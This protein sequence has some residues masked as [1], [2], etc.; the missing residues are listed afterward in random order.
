MVTSKFLTLTSLSK[1]SL[2]TIRAF[3][4]AASSLK[5]IRSS[6]SSESTGVIRSGLAVPVARRLAQRLEL[7]VPPGVLLVGLPGG[8]ELG[9]D[10]GGQRGA[11]QGSAGRSSREK[12]EREGGEEGDDFHGNG[13][14][15]S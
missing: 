15:M 5:P 10:L 1:E 4:F 8:E 7:V 2:S 13:Y 14:C 11:V 6:V 12:E 9:A 3:A